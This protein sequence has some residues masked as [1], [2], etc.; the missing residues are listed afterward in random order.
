MNI[1]PDF[2]GAIGGS[3]CSWL[4]GVSDFDVSVSVAVAVAVAIA[5]EEALLRAAMLKLYFAQILFSISR[6]CLGGGFDLLSIFF[7]KMG[8]VFCSY[9]SKRI[10]SL[11]WSHCTNEILPAGKLGHV[12]FSPFESQYCKL[13]HLI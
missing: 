5:L 10:V 12:E 1:R 6:L 7:L 3:A 4:V 11:Y 9:V 2:G 8:F 13:C